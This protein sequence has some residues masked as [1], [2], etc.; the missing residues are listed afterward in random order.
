M[1]RKVRKELTPYQRR[2]LELID[3]IIKDGLN[4]LNTTVVIC[5]SEITFTPE[6]LHLYYARQGKRFALVS[7]AV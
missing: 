6:D 5:G 3:E 2:K 4:P 7:T 1:A